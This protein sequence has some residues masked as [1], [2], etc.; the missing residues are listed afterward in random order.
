[1]KTLLH[2]DVLMW[3]MKTLLTSGC[4]NQRGAGHTLTAGLSG[5]TPTITVKPTSGATVTQQVAG[6]SGG[7]IGLI[8]KGTSGQTLSVRSTAHYVL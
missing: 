1:G 3:L 6:F 7:K 2:G 8:N 4:T 5:T